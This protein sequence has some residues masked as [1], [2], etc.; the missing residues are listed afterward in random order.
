MTCAKW[1]FERGAHG[2]GGLGRDE[3]PTNFT[4]LKGPAMSIGENKRIVREFMTL[5]ERSAFAELLDMMAEEATWTIAGKPHLFAGAGVK[6]KG[7]MGSIWEGL[8]ETLDGGLEMKVIGMVAEDDRVAAEVRSHATTKSGKIY[9]NDYHF[10]IVV[11]DGKIA[12][13]KE[14]T[15]LMHAAEVFG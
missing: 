12:Q 5:F 9:D 8:Y 10:L 14:Y 11:R 4:P 7:Q 13:I 1:F 2:R 15:D 3:R 6:T